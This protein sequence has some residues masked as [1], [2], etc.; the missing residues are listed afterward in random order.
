MDTS[1]KQQALSSRIIKLQNIR[2][3]DLKFV[4]Q[5]EFKEWVDSGDQKLIQSLLKYQ[6]VDPFKVWEQSPD[7][8][9]CLDGF[10][11]FRDL[12]ALEKLGIDVPEELPANFIDCDDMKEAAELVLVYSSIYARITQGGLSD[13]LKNYDIN[14]DDLKMTVALPEFDSIKFESMFASTNNQDDIIPRSLQERFIIPP[15]SVFDSRQGYWQERKKIWNGLFNSQA[16]R[17]Q[18][19]LIAKSGQAPA[20]YELR[21][22]MRK[23]LGREPEWN[24][25]IEYARKKGLHIYEGGSI[26]DPVVCEICYKWFCPD[27]GLILDPFAGGSVRGI[28]AGI[29]GYDYVGVDLREEQVTENKEQWEKLNVP[30]DKMKIQWMQG[31]S[32]NLPSMIQENI[33]FDFVF[34]CPPY[35]D[36][37][38]YSDDPADLSN[39]DYDQFLFC[40]RDIIF[41][42]MTK[43]KPNRFACFVVGDIR[44]KKG[45]YRNFVSQTIEAFTRAEH[46]DGI[47]V[48]L[49]NEIILV[50][51]AG[52]LPVRI[53]RQFE[54]YR[55]VG[56]MH[57]NI[58]VFYKGDPK[59]IKEEFPEIKV[60]EYLNELNNQPNIAM[61]VIE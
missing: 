40:Y 20:V 26:F 45:N 17:E 24:E 51:V 9:Y 11:R 37:E 55:K 13:F 22:Q 14:Y 44:D 7:V 21:N 4:Q 43:L 59:K 16:T 35:H 36:L 28:V 15:F 29:L 30:T 50:N 23:S 2:W 41:K 61:P 25:I 58:L 52:S 32:G 10:H 12:A 19:E 39:M 42:S 60:D 57:Q 38:K 1:E 34:S 8:I 6:F 49:Y 48:N 46:C 3:K 47:P 31:N 27:G 56:K 54:G 5:E 18:T 33:F 53:G